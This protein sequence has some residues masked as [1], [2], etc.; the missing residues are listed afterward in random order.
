VV[1]SRL[2]R[3]L[4]F[5]PAAAVLATYFAMAVGAASTE[6]VTFDEMAHLTAGYTYW[7]YDDYRIHPENGNWPQRW[8]ALPVVMGDFRFPPLDQPGWTMS[9]M[10]VMGDQFFYMSGNDPAAML[11]RGRAMI[12]LLGVAL[13]ALVFAWARRLI[14]PTAAWLSLLL[15]AFSPSLLAHGALVTSDMAAALL[16][17]AAAGAMWVALHRLTPWTLAGSAVLV[18]GTFLTKFSGP[19]LLFVGVAMA[20]VRL[21]GARPLILEWRAARIEYA[22]RIKQVGVIACVVLAYAL[23]AWALMW[24]SYGFRYSAFAAATT[25][26]E[27]FMAPL[28]NAPGLTTTLV[29]AAQEYRLL[30]EAYLYGFANTMQYAAG[31]AAFLNGEFSINGWWWFF[32]YSFLVKTTLPALLIGLIAIAGFI[33]QLRTGQTEVTWWRR[34]AAGLYAGTPLLALLGVYWLFVLTSHLNIGHRHLLPIYPALC[35]LA[36]GAAFWIEPLVLPWFE[37]WAPVRGHT[38]KQRRKEQVRTASVRLTPRWAKAAGA[39]TL[40]LLAWHAVESIRISPHYLA[41][42]NQLAGGPSR[43]YRH[44]VDSSL[45]WGQDLPGLKQ[46]LDQQGLQPPPAGTPVYLS[47]FGTA[48][49]EFYGIEARQLAGFVD[50][51]PRQPLEPLA[52]GVYCVSA[53]ILNEIGYTFW[54]PGTEVLYQ[55]LLATVAAFDRT[56]G[57]TQARQALLQR[58]GEE[59]W[60][61]TFLQ[62]DQMRMGRLAAFL[63]QREPNA[64]VGFSILVYRLTDQEVNAAIYGPAPKS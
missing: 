18:A 2:G 58:T 25:G 31:R 30:P 40:V 14:S 62:F 11:S 57:D 41:Y 10:Y 45:D 21:A 47:Y 6:C 46:W 29:Q 15:F 4:R 27:T 44:L 48:R 35:I 63:R 60:W 51:R 59:F 1:S 33:A 17:T 32:P 43:G 5:W 50:R 55:R 64:Q 34:M 61:R 23:V 39:A 22:G 3:L 24:A 49:P 12:A 16:F 28:T 36:G 53:T 37:R 52:G 9:N 42:F 56:A 19:I 38:G 13:G 8:A 26:H 20:L 7:A 54:L